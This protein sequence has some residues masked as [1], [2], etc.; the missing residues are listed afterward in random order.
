MMYEEV[1]NGFSSL[2]RDVLKDKLAGVYLHGSAVMGCFNPE[3]SDIDIIV[4]VNAPLTEDEKLEFMK[5]TVALNAIAP[6]K[7]I[8]M[9][10]VRREF[11][12]PFVYPTPYELHFS[13]AHLSLWES[14]HEEYIKELQG[15]DC[16]LAAHF[17]VISTYGKVLYGEAIEKV[18]GSVPREDYIDSIL[19]DVE[20]AREDIRTS[21]IYTTLNL[22]RVSA[23][24]KDGLILSKKAGGKWALKSLPKKYYSLIQ[25]ALDSYTSSSDAEISSSDAFEFADFMLYDIEKELAKA[26]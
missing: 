22:C 23:Y 9:S 2:C 8:E 25:S 19:Y 15:E 13:N 18:F 21:P 3:K 12:D 17:T 11:C 6:K 10:I 14:S 4:I 7:G 1:I 26:L 16:D 5:G 20:N 24:L